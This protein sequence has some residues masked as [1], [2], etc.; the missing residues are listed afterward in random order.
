MGRT[1]KWI[2]VATVLASATVFLDGTVVNVALPRIGRD[3]P[4]SVVGVLE[5]QTYIY[6]GHLLSLSTLLILSGPLTDVY[7]RRP[8]FM[9]VLAR[10]RL[11]SALC[12]LAPNLA[13]PV[14]LPV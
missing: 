6:T 4:H 9:L 1:Q 11:T 8:I 5:G 12:P 14:V 13:P 3:L 2:L 7:G 10:F